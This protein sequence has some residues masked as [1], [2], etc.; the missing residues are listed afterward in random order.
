[1]LSVLFSLITYIHPFHV[2][3]TDIKYKADEKVIQISTSIFLDDLELGLR[4]YA[5]IE[6]LDILDKSNWEY[7][8]VTLEK[9]IMKRVTLSDEKGRSYDI[10]YIGA[11]IEDDVMWCYL[12]VERVKKIRSVIVTNK[13]LHEIWADQE[14]LVHFRA[15]DTVKSNRHI[16]GEET[17]KFSWE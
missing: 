11:E 1:M 17:K 7:V 12:E 8:N 2:S 13:I 5:G 14:N 16:K 4:A 10:K 3:V 15:F 6:T 9:Y